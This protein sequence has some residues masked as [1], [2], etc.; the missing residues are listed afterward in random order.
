MSRVILKNSIFLSN[1]KQLIKIG[2]ILSKNVNIYCLN[3]RVYKINTAF[4]RITALVFNNSLIGRISR[5]DELAGKTDFS[6]FTGSLVL[7]NLFSWYPFIRKK[8]IGCFEVSFF[9]KLLK[10]AR[11]NLNFSVAGVTA[12]ILAAVVL[13]K[14]FISILAFGKLS[15]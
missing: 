9:V 15:L 11:I 10:Q 7:G 12:I 3:S 5:V 8:I 6:V 2:G 1:I 13:I 14:A 4:R